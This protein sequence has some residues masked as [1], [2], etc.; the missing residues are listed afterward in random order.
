MPTDKHISKQKHWNRFFNEL[1]CYYYYYYHLN[2]VQQRLCHD[3]YETSKLLNG[4]KKLKKKEKS[5]LI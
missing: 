4:N 1:C 5:N 3:S 2:R